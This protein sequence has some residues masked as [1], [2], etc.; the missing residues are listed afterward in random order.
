MIGTAWFTPRSHGAQQHRAWSRAQT[1]KVLSC[2]LAVGR[3]PL[4][5]NFGNKHIQ[6]QTSRV[7]SSQDSFHSK[8]SPRN[9]P[10]PAVVQRVPPGKRGVAQQQEAQG[11][12]RTGREAWAWAGRRAVRSRGHAG[13]SDTFVQIRPRFFVCIA[14]CVR[15]QWPAGIDHAW[16]GI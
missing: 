7:E 11:N 5:L 1:Q 9:V 12:Q 8:S 6:I 2:V 10:V 15:K 3:R 13:S 14:A 4:V 16:S